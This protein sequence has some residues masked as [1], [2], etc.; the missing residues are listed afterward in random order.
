M[1]RLLPLGL[2]LLAGPALAHPGT[3]QD[4]WMSTLLHLLSEPDH[5]AL[6]LVAG[7]VGI[8]G[9]RALRRWLS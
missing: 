8:A 6:A 1:S 2:T 7:V 5:L 3:H 4:A 9:A